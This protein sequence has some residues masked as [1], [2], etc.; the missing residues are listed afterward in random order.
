[1]EIIPNLHPIFVHFTVVLVFFTGLLQLCLWLKK[2]LQLN[3]MALSVQSW[4]VALS[5]LSLLATL[6]TGLQAF[7]SVGHDAPSHMAMTD[8][9]NWAF[10]TASV[11]FA[12]DLLFYFLPMRR[13]SVA[14]SFWLAALLLVTLT[15]FKG[16]ELVYRYGM[17]VMS[18]PQVSGDGHDHEHGGQEEKAAIN[19][20]AAAA[21]SYLDDEHSLVA[22]VVEEAHEADSQGDS[23]VDGHAGHRH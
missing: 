5:V 9:R 15:A 12:G 18:L 16:G 4:L 11:F 7:Y 3:A 10:A 14:A 19:P 22:P 21:S 17:G 8:H 2:P 1:M 13:Q 23:G 6:A 20:E